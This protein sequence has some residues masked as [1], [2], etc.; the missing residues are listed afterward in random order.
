MPRG[1]GP[2]SCLC[3][4]AINQALSDFLWLLEEQQ[5]ELAVPANRYASARLPSV[6]GPSSS[7]HR[8]AI[9][10]ACSDFLWLPEE[11]HAEPPIP[12]NPYASACL[13]G[14]AG[15]SSSSHRQAIN[16]TRSDF[17]RRLEER[18]AELP[19]PANGRPARSGAQTR[20][21]W[22]E[23]IGLPAIAVVAVSFF[24]CGGHS[25]TVHRASCKQCLLLYRL[26]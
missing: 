1:D 20:R 15:S 22:F 10:Q 26:C 25:A 3:C 17:V 13:P 7:I 8:Q 24:A 4:Q 19:V 23:T 12:A 16:Q 18:Q 21:R 14:G 6:D 11:Q 2:S 9:N 5:K